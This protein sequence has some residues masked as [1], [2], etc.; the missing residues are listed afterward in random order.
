MR[1]FS[2]LG[3]LLLAAACGSFGCTSSPTE[4]EKTKSPTVDPVEFVPAPVKE[5]GTMPYK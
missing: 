3:V 2:L 1:A 4:V 5:R